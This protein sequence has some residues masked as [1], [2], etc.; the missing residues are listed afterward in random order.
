[1]IVNRYVVTQLESITRQ[2]ELELY[3]CSDVVR[4]LDLKIE[5][6]ELKKANDLLQLVKT[7][8]DACIAAVNSGNSGFVTS[9]DRI[10]EKLEALPE[11]LVS[12]KN[13]PLDDLVAASIQNYLYMLM[14]HTLVAKNLNRLPRLLSDQSY[15][16]QVFRSPWYNKALYGLQVLPTKL[17]RYAKNNNLTELPTKLR[18][19]LK[20]HSLQFVGISMKRPWSWMELPAAMVET[21]VLQRAESLERQTNEDVSRF[22]QLIHRFPKDDEDKFQVFR[23][24]FELPPDAK[25]LDVVRKISK[26]DIS[27]SSPKPSWIARHWPVILLAFMGGPSTVLYVWQSRYNIISFLER[28]LV[29]FTKDL[30]TNW[31]IEPIRNIWSTVRHDPNS[32]VALMSQGTLNTEVSSLQR[33][34]IDF[35]KEHEDGNTIDTDVLLKQVEFGNLTQF[36][37]IYE[38]QLKKPVKN[39]LTG[40]LIRALLIQIQKGKV[41]GS[42]AVHGI[43]QILQS[44]Q[45][46]FGIVSISPALIILYTVWTSISKLFRYGTIWMGTSQCRSEIGVSMN[47]VERLL[48]YSVTSPKEVDYWN[49]GLLTLEMANLR[50]LGQKLVPNNRMLEWFRDIDDLVSNTTLDAQAKL[51]VINRI[52][53]VYGKYF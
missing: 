23:D 33:M 48:N 50:Q 52:Y 28:N 18:N 22:G 43:D 34:I 53:H 29:Q 17:Y 6:G 42:I 14:Y 20:I 1:M 40:D 32:S 9:F 5:D 8:T 41:D 21:D 35:V 7:E 37:E 16:E 44:Q 27:Y 13:A 10:I 15:Y 26:W 11:Q 31:V 3:A 12:T 47:N 39:I 25:L 49:T 24:F 46:V 30:I 4:S 2:L 45:L 19:T 51:N 38:A 36:M